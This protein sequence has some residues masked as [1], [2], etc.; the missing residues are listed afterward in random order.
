MCSF[1][2]SYLSDLMNRYPLVIVTGIRKRYPAPIVFTTSEIS[3]GGRTLP[4]LRLM[5]ILV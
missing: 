1:R 2:C 5:V 4:L 3:P